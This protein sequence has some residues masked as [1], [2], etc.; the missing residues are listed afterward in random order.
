MEDYSNRLVRRAVLSPV[1]GK[2]KMGAAVYLFVYFPDR[3]VIHPFVRYSQ[4]PEFRPLCYDDLCF[5][6]Y[7]CR[8]RL[9]FCGGMAVEAYAGECREVY[10]GHPIRNYRYRSS[11]QCICIPALLLHLLQSDHGSNAART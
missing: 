8:H 10:T 5:P 3:I 6:G 4:R 9:G 1:P 2:A 11:G 7:A